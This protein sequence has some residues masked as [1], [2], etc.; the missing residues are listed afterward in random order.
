MVAYHHHATLGG[1]GGRGSHHARQILCEWHHLEL[2]FRSA[3][4][5]WS[6]ELSSA[7]TLQPR[8]AGNSVS[9][10]LHSQMRNVSSDN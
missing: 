1:G 7:A 3:V 8:D 2:C 10:A 9:F 5:G 4:S 6:L